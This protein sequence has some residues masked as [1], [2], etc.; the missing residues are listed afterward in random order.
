MTKDS[1]DWFCW[2]DPVL[3]P[4]GGVTSCG[5][6]CVCKLDG[7]R[8]T[9]EGTRKPEDFAFLLFGRCRDGNHREPTRLVE[10]ELPSSGAQLQGS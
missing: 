10:P 6:S 7:R 5:A 9:E 3:S 1:T 4:A 2:C 8:T